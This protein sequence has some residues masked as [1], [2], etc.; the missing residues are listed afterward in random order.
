MTAFFGR[1][2]KRE[3]E[4]ERKRERE[5]E[6]VN[7][8]EGFEKWKKVMIQEKY[9]CDS[10]EPFL[11]VRFCKYIKKLFGFSKNYIL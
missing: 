1:D 6:I 9:I 10:W 3:R 5:R 7:Q 2:G 4:R 8:T 11:T